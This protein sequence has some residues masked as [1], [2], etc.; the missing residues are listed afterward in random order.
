MAQKPV[1]AK[2]KKLKVLF[3]KHGIDISE[4]EFIEI[5]QVEY[6]R[7]WVRIQEIYKLQEEN[8]KTG[9]AA[10]MPEPFQYLRNMYKVYLK[11]HS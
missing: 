3:E 9:K 6:P 4:N 7:D 8:R 11:K 5:F 10:P 2:E 1:P